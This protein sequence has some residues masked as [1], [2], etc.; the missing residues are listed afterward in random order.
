M[1]TEE[2]KDCAEVITIEKPYESI[3]LGVESTAHPKP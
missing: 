2:L 3:S 1:L